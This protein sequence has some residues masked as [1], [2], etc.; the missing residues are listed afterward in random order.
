MLETLVVVFREG[1]EA[2]LII[3]IML[4]YLNKIGRFDLKK[5]VYAGIMLA[6]IISLTTGWHVADLAQDPV[7]E[8]SLAIAAGLLV[9]TFTLYVMRTAKNIRGNIDTQLEKASQKNRTIAIFGVFIFTVLMISREGM[10]TALMLG[11][12]GAQQD[13]MSMWI[14]AILAF[15]LIGLIGYLWIK[16]SSKINLRIFLQVTGVFLI[17]FSVYLF[18]YGLHELSELARIPFIGEQANFD[19]H[20]ATEVIEAPLVSNLISLGLVGVPLL[21]LLTSYFRTKPLAK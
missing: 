6:L 18:F 20:M 14:G 1:L 10:E 17:L 15:L 16:Q 13:G 5:S 12:I 21:W 3:A 2:F 19:F 11:T 8:G 4:A 9:A 7:W